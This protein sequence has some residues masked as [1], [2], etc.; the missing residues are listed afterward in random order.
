MAYLGDNGLERVERERAEG[1]EERGKSWRSPHHHNIAHGPSSITRAP[2]DG[3]LSVQVACYDSLAL[4]TRTK[5][6]DS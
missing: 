2:E 3:D 4:H 6:I 5:G 1:K